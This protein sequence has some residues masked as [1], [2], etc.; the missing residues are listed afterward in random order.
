MLGT[1][2][3]WGKAGPL[4]KYDAVGPGLA[5][6]GRGIVDSVAAAALID[7]KGTAVGLEE[8]NENV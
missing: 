6:D 8:S 3:A 1:I 7:D 5:V 2:E 4:L